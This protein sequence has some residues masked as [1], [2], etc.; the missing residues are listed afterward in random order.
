MIQPRMIASRTNAMN[1]PIRGQN[2][3]LETYRPGPAL[4][5]EGH[6]LA[7]RRERVGDLQAPLLAEYEPQL[8]GR[9]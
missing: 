1:P 3:M 6:L 2:M 8:A 4:C 7:R 9:P 5:V